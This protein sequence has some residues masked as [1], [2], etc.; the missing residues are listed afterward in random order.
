MTRRASISYIVLLAFFIWLATYAGAHAASAPESSV[1]ILVYVLFGSSAALGGAAAAV[2]RRAKKLISTLGAQDTDLTVF[3]PPSA[4]PE[5]EI[6]IQVMIHTPHRQSEPQARALKIEPLAQ[7]LASI[8]LTL[9]LSRND[10]IKISLDCEGT[11]I[12]DAVQHI[13]WNGRSVFL[14]FMM[15]LPA[16]VTP[17][18]L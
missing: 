18:T 9:Q 12:S 2:A 10:R 3:A 7:E 15:R 5:S 14:Y 16:T 4:P 6:I 8:P 11:Q 17:I 13:N 1:D